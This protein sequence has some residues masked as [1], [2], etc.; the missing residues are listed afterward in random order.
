MLEKT[1]WSN[2]EWI[3]QR[4]WQHLAYMNEDKK[5][6]RKHNTE[7]YDQHGPHQ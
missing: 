5:T 6:K 4:Q 2:A 7:K 1:E 3:I